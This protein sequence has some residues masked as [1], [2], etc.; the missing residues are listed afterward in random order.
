VKEGEQCQVQS[1]VSTFFTDLPLSLH[2]EAR[3]V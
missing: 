3:M 1:V 2:R